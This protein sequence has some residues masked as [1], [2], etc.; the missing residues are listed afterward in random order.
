MCWAPETGGKVE[1]HVLVILPESWDSNPAAGLQN[2]SHD[3]VQPH[4]PSE[5][6]DWEVRCLKVTLHAWSPEMAFAKCAQVG[7]G[8]TRKRLRGWVG[9]L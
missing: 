4:V 2:S 9:S 7:C 3:V 8:M 5:A 1:G 6:K